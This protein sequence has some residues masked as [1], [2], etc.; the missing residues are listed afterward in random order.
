MWS[1]LG[2]IFLHLP[3]LMD[4]TL[5]ASE[6]QD[7]MDLC[8]LSFER[9]EFLE[10]SLKVGRGSLPKL[11]TFCK[12]ICILPL[13]LLADDLFASY[14]LKNRHYFVFGHFG[15]HHRKGSVK[16]TEQT[17]CSSIMLIQVSSATQQMTVFPVFHLST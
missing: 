7:P 9:D 16:S 8:T 6:H 15:V 1:F 4:C 2:A 12:H 13:I 5:F 11:S 14:K 3:L 17:F 10:N